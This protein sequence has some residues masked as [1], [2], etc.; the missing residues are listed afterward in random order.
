MM[1]IGARVKYVSGD[2][3]DHTI[4][5]LWDGKHGQILGTVIDGSKS[6][7]IKIEKI[8]ILSKEKG[9]PDKEINSAWS[10]IV[11]WDNGYVNSYE[12]SDLKVVN[13]SKEL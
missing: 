5:P 10:V 7:K 2:K 1:K 11:E 13:I 3:G 6:K 12:P 4:N 9:V 8:K